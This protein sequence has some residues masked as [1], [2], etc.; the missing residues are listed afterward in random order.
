[1]KTGLEWRKT[2]KKLNVF[3]TKWTDDIKK[4]WSFL[5]K[6]WCLQTRCLKPVG[7]EEP[8]QSV[9]IAENCERRGKKKK[10][11]TQWYPVRCFKT[12]KFSELERCAEVTLPAP[13]QSRCPQ[14]ETIDLLKIPQLAGDRALITTTSI[15]NYPD[16]FPPVQLFLSTG[17]CQPLWL[18]PHSSLPAF[19]LEH[20]PNPLT[21][22]HT[23]S[24][25]RNVV[26]IGLVFFLH[27]SITFCTCAVLRFNVLHRTLNVSGLSWGSS[28]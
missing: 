24:M 10:W 15:D 18:L 5:T 21:L 11:V 28:G 27:P 6:R 25:H 13:F 19:P 14:W 23:Q 20:S 12:L 26:W 7:S 8:A 4:N 1:M 9:D 2:Q 16:A 3:L 22:S 17:I